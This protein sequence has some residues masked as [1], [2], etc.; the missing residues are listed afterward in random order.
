MKILEGKKAI[1]TGAST[2]LGPVMA[3]MMA[4][5]GAKLVLAARRLELVAFINQT[6]PQAAQ[7]ELGGTPEI[8][9]LQRPPQFIPRVSDNSPQ[10]T[11]RPQRKGNIR[12]ACSRS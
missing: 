7:A 6:D 11:R 3:Q 10:S 9:L 1:I 2:G 12:L 5:E 4:D 8:T